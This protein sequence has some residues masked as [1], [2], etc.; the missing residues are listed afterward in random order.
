MRCSYA[1]ALQ[2]D[3]KLEEAGE[4]AG[5]GTLGGLRR[6]VAL[7]LA[8]ALLSGWLFIFL[9][10][11]KVL[12]VAILLS[13]PQSQMMAVAIYDMWVNGEAGKV[14]VLGLSW[15]AFMVVISSLFF[16]MRDRTGRAFAA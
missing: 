16:L 9:L 4:A 7:L 8:P 5:A 14:S 10:G 2:I 15:T 3:R 12:S 11:S 1:G 6:I 13:G